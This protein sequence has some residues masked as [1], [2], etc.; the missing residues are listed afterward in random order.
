MI[1]WAAFT[2]ASPEIASAGHRL[3]KDNE[4]A[5][6]AS[7]TARGRP[8]L[9]PFVPRIVDGRLVAFIMDSS[10]KL[11]D[12][13]P[14]GHYA[15]HAWPG[16][17]DEEFVIGGEA[18]CCDDDADLREVA[19]EAM[20]FATGVDAHHILFEFF[21]DQALWTRWLDFGTANHRPSRQRWCADAQPES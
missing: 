18:R 21:I 14:T 19:A 15:L 9:H 13:S 17:E 8:R 6:L 3:L 12:L 7:V 5:F 2:E 20:G 4:V 11:K 10:P 16:P 1:G